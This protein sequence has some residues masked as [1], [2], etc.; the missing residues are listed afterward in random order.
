MT[1]IESGASPAPNPSFFLPFFPRARALLLVGF[2]IT[3]GAAQG[4]LAQALQTER[5]LHA[6]VQDLR[7]D[8]LDACEGLPDERLAEIAALV[9]D[10]EIDPPLQP[11]VR[12]LARARHGVIELDPGAALVG[13]FLPLVLPTVV[14]QDGDATAILTTLHLPRVPPA[15]AERLEVAWVDVEG[16]DADGESVGVDTIA[17]DLERDDLMRFA[18][19]LR[20]DTS[21]W[22]AGRYLVW[23]R[24]RLHGVE[25]ERTAAAPPLAQPVWIVP[26]YRSRATPFFERDRVRADFAAG[27]GPS[28]RAALWAA[29]EPVDAVWRGLPRTPGMDPDR[30]LRVLERVVANVEKERPPYAGIADDLPPD[31]PVPVGFDLDGAGPRGVVRVRVAASALATDAPPRPLVVVVGGT[32]RWARGGARPTSPRMVEGSWPFAACVRGGLL[33]GAEDDGASVH[34]A[35]LDSAGEV[36]NMADAI[37]TAVLGLLEVVPVA[38]EQGAEGRPRVVLVGEREGAFHLYLALRKHA[39]LPCAALAFVDGGAVDESFAERLSDRP[40]LVVGSGD[41]DGARRAVALAE[42]AETLGVDVTGPESR[43][44]P[45]PVALGLSAPAIRAFALSAGEGR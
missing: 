21:D 3:S 25:P 8:L 30:D 15:A 6:W 23:M 17:R 14:S 2:A 5:Q 42:R 35:A 34:L 45:W 27:V 41:A 20:F 40:L 18:S 19:R 32:P 44:L 12:A 9:A 36:T 38:T 37:R 10:E 13:S 33:D 16:F 22:P 1:K 43:P 7:L 4:L 29:I 31:T 24:P 26:G 11:L 28:A 39:D